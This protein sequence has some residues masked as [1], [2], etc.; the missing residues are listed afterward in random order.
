MRRLTLIPFIVLSSAAYAQEQM[1]AKVQACADIADKAVR[2]ACFDAAI[3]TYRSAAPSTNMAQPKAA[4]PE[5]ETADSISIGVSK[6]EPGIEGKLRFTLE[7]GQVW[8]QTDSVALRN[9][10]KGPWKAQLKQA[11]LGSFML[12]V[13]N[14]TPV[15]VKRVS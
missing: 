2:L 10:G 7:D 15:R 3:A 12:K 13:D 11:A 1:P 8:R 4:T 14:R 6:I 9:L 5:D